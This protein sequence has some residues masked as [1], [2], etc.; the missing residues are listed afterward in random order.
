[1]FPAPSLRGWSLFPF[2]FL[3]LSQSRWIF[4]SIFL[5]IGFAAFSLVAYTLRYLVEKTPAG[6][7]CFSAGAA[8]PCVLACSTTRGFPQA[9]THSRSLSYRFL[10]HPLSPWRRVS[11]GCKSLRLLGLLFSPASS[12]W[13]ALFTKNIAEFLVSSCMKISSS[14]WCSYYDCAHALSFLW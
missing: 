8:T 5:G 1:M 11:S 12:H 4:Y 14:S 6:T 13:W 3:H 2:L 10:M 9:S 7:W